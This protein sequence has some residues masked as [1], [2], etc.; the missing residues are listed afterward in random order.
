MMLN[1]YGLRAD[2]TE[3]KLTVPVV[4]TSFSQVAINN[5]NR[6]TGLFINVSTS[7]IWIFP[8]TNVSLGNGILLIPQGG[9]FKVEQWEDVGFAYFPWYAIASAGGSNLMFI[10]TSINNQ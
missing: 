7:S 4:G 5:P 10:E 6:L 9:D 3:T 8:N 2:Q 1:Q